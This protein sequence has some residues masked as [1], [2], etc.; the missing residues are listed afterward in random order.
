MRRRSPRPKNTRKHRRPQP[1]WDNGLRRSGKGQQSLATW[2][3]CIGTF[4]SPENALTT[5]PCHS[6]L[7][8]DSLYTLVGDQPISQPTT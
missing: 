1:E 4:I 8:V 7:L 5:L 3:Q 6:W 2:H